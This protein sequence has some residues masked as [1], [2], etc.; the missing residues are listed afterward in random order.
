[1]KKKVFISYRHKTNSNFVENL[2]LFLGRFYDVYYDNGKKTDPSDVPVELKKEINSSTH[3]LLIVDEKTFDFKEESDWV[4]FEIQHVLSRQKKGQNI[5]IIPFITPKGKWP[6]KGD[7]RVKKYHLE[8]LIDKKYL[9]MTD[10]KDSILHMTEDDRNNLLN[11]I[12]HET[13]FEKYNKYALY[14]FVG[15]VVVVVVLGLFYGGFCFQQHISSKTVKLVFAGGG[16]V[17]NIIKDKYSVDCKTYENSLYL[18]LPSEHAWPLMA[19]EVMNNHSSKSVRNKF[20]P[21]CL[22][23][24][25]ANDSDFTKI[26]DSEK[27]KGQGS[28]ISY[29]LGDDPLIVYTN[30]FDTVNTISIQELSDTISTWIDKKELENKDSLRLYITQEGSGTYYCYRQLI[31]NNINI[32]IDTYKNLLTWYGDSLRPDQL[33][34]PNESIKYVILTSKY[35]TPDRISKHK[36]EQKKVVVD[37]DGKPK[38]KPL[39]LYFVAHVNEGTFTIP[40]EMVEFLNKTVGQDSTKRIKTQIRQDTPKIITPFEDLIEWIQSDSLSN[41]VINHQ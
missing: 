37:K 38:T 21:V 1:M 36:N 39:F 13:A 23:A 27:F 14:I 18:S 22:S 25:E 31:K 19:E 40:E 33:V 26:V 10:K 8:N 4:L 34:F 17:A 12:N 2:S 41:N 6:S 20:Y 16:S 29:Y 5:T 3:F 28:V 32:D 30:L 24:M 7:E 9:Q 35:Y 15:V 11:M